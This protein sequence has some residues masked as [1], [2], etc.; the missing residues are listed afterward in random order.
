MSSPTPERIRSVAVLGHSHDGKT[1]LCEALM[2]V[3]GATAR[4]G[5]TDQGTSIL[6]FEP[7]EPRA[8]GDVASQPER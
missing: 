6:D 7:E 1:T 3:A 8:E 5:S 4:L 2:H